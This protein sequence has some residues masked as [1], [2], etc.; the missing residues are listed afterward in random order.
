M[1]LDVWQIKGLQAHSADLWQ[2]TFW[3]LRANYQEMRT[4]PDKWSRTS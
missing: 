1:L 4:T 2:L 3:R